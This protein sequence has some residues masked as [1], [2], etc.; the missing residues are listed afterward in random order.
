MKKYYLFSLLV[1]IFACS[2]QNKTTPDMTDN[3][4]LSEWNTPFG[5]PPFDKIRNADYQP[6]FEAAMAMH[7]K[8]IEEIVN[9]PEPPTFANTIEALERSG[10]MLGRVSRVFFAVHGAHTNDSL[11][12]VA[13]EI[14]PKLSA[15][16]DDITLNADL[17]KR[18]DAVYQQKDTLNLTAEQN[19]LLE[20]TYKSF[21]RS[22]IN[23]PADKQQRLREINAELAQLAQQFGENLLHETNATK[24]LVTD[25]ADLGNLPASLVAAAAKEAEK[26]GQQGWL[27]TLQRPSINPFLQYSPNREL[28]K[29]LF[30]G[31]AMRGDNDNE[32]DNKEILS[33]MA[34][35]RVERAQLKGYDT[36]AAYI[37]SDNMA[38]NPGRVYDFLDKVWPAALNR[39]KAERADLQAMMA[40]DG[41]D[42][43]LRGWDWRY[44][45]EKVRQ[46]RYAFDEETMRPY[47]EVSAVRDGAFMLANKLFGLTFKKL[48][49]IPTWHPDQEV[50]EV[51][52]ADG[53]HLGILYMD[54]F[55]RESKRG[56]AWMNEL[57]P[58]SK[59][60]GEVTPIV[61]NNFNFPPPTDGSPSLLS[62]TE[63][64]TLFHEFGHALHGLLSDVTYESL[65]G[66]NVPRDFVEFPSQVMENWMS[67]PEVLR[68]Y[69]R[70]YQT[71]EVIPDELIDKIVASGKFNQ[72]FATVEYM[73][74]A[75]LDMAWHTLTDTTRQD[76][77]AFEDKEMQRIGLIE[78]I[79]P[80]Y[81]STYFN[82][83]FGGDPSYSA[84]YYS[85][86][87][88]EVL[89][90]DTFE[91]FKEA[92]IFDQETARRY[93]HLL[94]QGGTRPGMELYVEFRGREPAI[95]PLLKKR[96]LLEE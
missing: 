55:A 77:R 20:E 44:Y 47:F 40:R 62:F 2:Q 79:I 10:K 6:A 88:S 11:R 82:H 73:A 69:A 63:A 17:F 50:F 68:L 91:A 28:R 94:S 76:A 4:L 80:R 96:G 48:D 85:Y 90:A 19:R 66:T 61:T 81:R 83:I 58:Q 53:S 36:H 54:F 33:R 13:K 72:G 84:G 31:Y 12:A 3:P 34:A 56:G 51:L 32:Y 92:G 38:E 29:K 14:A 49:N 16:E 21:V 95:E 22:G 41:I 46:E 18:V 39:A 37:L 75:Y 25:K 15:H 45:T 5:V 59:L 24:V 93:R 35:L 67:E 30:M 27:F 60:D 7:K 42:D 52:D 86:L 87:W 74:A 64:S 9:N 65:S 70:H 89:D 8:E 57:R 43:K 23:L 1:F 78:E 71:G 26:N